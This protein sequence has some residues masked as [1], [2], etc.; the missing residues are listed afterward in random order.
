MVFSFSVSLNLFSTSG[1][2]LGDFGGLVE[3]RGGGV[4]L[5]VRSLTF[6]SF[7][8]PEQSP[9]LRRVV[10]PVPNGAGY[11]SSPPASAQ[12]AGQNYL[13][14]IVTFQITVSWIGVEWGEGTGHPLAQLCHS[15]LGDH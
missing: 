7:L 4:F 11:L 2:I 12:R 1:V 9:T 6:T 5:E 15:H 14:I 3:V 10:P 8:N 13:G